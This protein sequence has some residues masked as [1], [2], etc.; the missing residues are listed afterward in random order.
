MRPVLH[1]DVVAAARVLYRMPIRLRPDAMK[2]MLCQASMADRYRLVTGRLHPEWG[3]GSLMVAA[4]AKAPPP[5]PRLDDRDY[6]GCMAMVF[7]ALVEW[8]HPR[9][10]VSRGRR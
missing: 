4:L 5:E 3:D 10:R 6:C 7:E 8:L 1:G 9:R 2:R